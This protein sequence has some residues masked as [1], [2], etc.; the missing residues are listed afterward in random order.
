MITRHATSLGNAAFSA[1]LSAVGLYVVNES[2]SYEIGT[3]L[4]PGAGFWPLFMG[5]AL[6]GLSVFILI[7]SLKARGTA[8]NDDEAFSGRDLLMLCSICGCL[9]IWVLVSSYAGW[10]IATFLLTLVLSK[11]YGLNGYVTP[12]VLSLAVTVICYLLFGVLFYTDLPS[13]SI[14]WQR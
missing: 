5:A 3:I 9:L 2:R 11:L 14:E 13:G 7:K 6:A 1:A 8:A 10:L 4:Q 12:L